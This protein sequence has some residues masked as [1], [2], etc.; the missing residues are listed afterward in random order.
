MLYARPRQLL[1]SMMTAVTRIGTEEY[2]KRFSFAEPHDQL[3]ANRR[4]TCFGPQ[5]AFRLLAD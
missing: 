3:M 4:Q 2:A 5:R 1:C